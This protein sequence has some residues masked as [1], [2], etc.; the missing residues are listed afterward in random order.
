MR[1]NSPEEALD[2]LKHEPDYDSLTAVL[3]YLFQGQSDTASFNIAKPSPLSSQIIQTLVADIAPNYWVLL[4]GDSQDGGEGRRKKSGTALDMLL[5]CLRNL[6]GINA[7]L[8]RLRTLIQEAKAERAQKAEAKRADIPLKLGIDLELLCALLDGDDCVKIAWTL[9][10]DSMESP[11]RRRP[12]AQELLALL[13]SG[14]ITSLAAEA[15]E[16]IRQRDKMNGSSQRLWV[17]EGAEYSLW[18]TRNVFHWVSQEP[19]ENDSKLCSELLGK[20]L[21]MG[22]FGRP[23]SPLSLGVN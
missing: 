8:V 15:E 7:V 18:M 4:K 13:G 1:V 5:R 9:S 2:I 12:L 11:A 20:V 14:R 23:A 22:H 21:R 17:S 19:S 10:A 16:I 3:R 6:T